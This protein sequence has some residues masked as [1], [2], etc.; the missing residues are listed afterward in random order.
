MDGTINK[1]CKKCNVLCS[2]E[3][4]YKSKN[5]RSYPDGRIDWL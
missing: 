3:K 2:V 5:N 1:Y 4:F